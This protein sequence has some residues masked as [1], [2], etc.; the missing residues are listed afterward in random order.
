MRA[1]LDTYGLDPK[2]AMGQNFLHDAH[3]RARIVA[4]LELTP[5][6]VVV[7]IGP[8]LGALTEGLIQTGAIVGAIEHD[9]DMVR[10]LNGRFGTEPRLSVRHQD[11]LDLDYRSLRRELCDGS[12]RKERPL[13]VAG[14]LPY[15]ITSPL[16]FSFLSQAARGSVSARAVFMIQNEVADRIASSPG[17]KVYGRLS[18]MVQQYMDVRKLFKVPPGAFLP[19]PKVTSAVIEL[20]VRQTPR[21]EVD[22]DSF[23]FVVKTAFAGRRKMLR[24]S[25]DGPFGRD[26]LADAFAQTGIADTA[27]PE[28]LSVEAFGALACALSPHMTPHA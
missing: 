19:P 24:K 22:E 21:V 17:S 13:V 6:D 12:N 8:G 14:N 16:I 5:E 1:L 3:M 25:L 18:V 2:K 11:A 15:H 27:R 23:A 26:A 28:T 10:V 4:A 9:A 7:E 20:R